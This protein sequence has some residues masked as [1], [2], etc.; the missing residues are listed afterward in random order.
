MIIRAS[1]PDLFLTSMLPAL[2]EIIFNRFDRHPAQYPQI[3][4]VMDSDRSIEQTSEVV[5][6]GTFHEVPENSAVRYDEPAPGFKQTYEHTQ[7]GL[8]F[9][10][11]H[12]M[13]KDD[14]WSIINK[15]AGELG[16]SSKET[17]ELTAALIFNRAF[18]TNYPGPDG[19]PLCATDHPLVKAGTQRNRPA[20][21]ADLDVSSL[22]IALT[23]FRRM[24]DQSGKRVRVKPKRLVVAPEGE[25][26]AT[27]LL[28]GSM[29]SDTANNTINAF[30]NRVGMGS[31]TEP[32]VWEYLTD[33]DAWFITA[34]KEDTELRFYWRERPGTVHAVDFDTR[35]I[36]SAMWYRMSVGF[37]SFYGVYGC[38]GN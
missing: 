3:F 36:K 8:G 12:V 25:F 30:R 32:F 15:L 5:G 2:D 27:E 24:R 6:L 31:F 1:F 38:P 18:D 28:G 20:A 9:R 7:Y 29:R 13:V 19:K 14:R 10:V 22:E 23:D 17:I 21:D 34:E 11:S 4:R 16:R 33:P 35:A 37:S 26:N